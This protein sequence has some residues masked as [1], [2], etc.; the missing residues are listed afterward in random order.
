VKAALLI[1]VTL[2]L[3]VL[4]ANFLIADNGYV[5]INFRG[6]LLEMSVF[7]LLL[8]LIVAYAAVRILVHIWR[9]PRQ[10]GEAVARRRTRKA[11]ERIT[12]GFIELGQG[13]FAR[14]ER[15]LTKG[16]RHSET[17]LLNYLAAARAAQAQGDTQRRDTWL[18][19]AVEQEPRAA[20]T[21]LMAQ[22]EL[23]ADAGDQDG[24]A[25]T[26]DK[27]LEASPA[28][29]EALRLRAELSFAAADW[30][31]LRK[32]LPRLRSAGAL[33]GGQLDEWTIQTWSALLTAPELDSAT[34]RS[35]WKS[36]PRD[37]RAQPRLVEAHARAL[38]RLDEGK[39]EAVLRKAL[40]RQWDAGLVRLYGELQDPAA[41]R[42]LKQAEKWL[43]Q[44][45]DD[46]ALLQTAA[47][48]CVREELWGKARSYYESAASVKPTPE[49]WHE[50][51]QLMLSMGEQEAAFAAFQKGLTQGYGDSQ[52]LRLPGA[53]FA[54]DAEPRAAET[55]PAR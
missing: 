47:R 26:L 34:C 27:V 5:L 2:A 51:G 1:L 13:N 4:A 23:Q 48:L 54:A 25:A 42:L 43:R 12:Q 37:L 50:L 36:L 53:P 46:P 18:A 44:H 29:A 32:L 39:V 15:L 7:G 14:G 17:P 9:A 38:I 16:I 22:A 28:H 45:P 6:Y 30:P 24:A 31:L 33:P 19:M 21:V 52:L 49:I 40:Q 20:T 35:L 41:I 55:S 8:V 11:G 10:L 3:G